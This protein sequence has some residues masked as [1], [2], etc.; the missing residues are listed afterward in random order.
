MLTACIASCSF[1]FSAVLRFVSDRRSQPT[2]WDVDLEMEVE[3]NVP[4]RLSP[5]Q[6]MQI[7]IY[8]TGMQALPM[9]NI[10]TKQNTLN[11]TRLNVKM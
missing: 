5:F 8:Y 4:D 9:A 1:F 11:K 3:K 10:I 6:T 7:F 2:S